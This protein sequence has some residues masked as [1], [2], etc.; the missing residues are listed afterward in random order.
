LIVVRH[1]RLRV[2]AVN[3]LYLESTL[4]QPP[5]S[6]GFG[7]VATPR[8]PLAAWRILEAF[9]EDHAIANEWSATGLSVDASPEF[10]T[11][12]ALEGVLKTLTALIGEPHFV[13]AGTYKGHPN[14]RYSWFTK[15]AER[16]PISPQ[17]LMAVLDI[18]SLLPK[19]KIQWRYPIELHFGFSFF[20]RGRSELQ[21]PP[22]RAVRNPYDEPDWGPGNPYSRLGILVRDHL[23]VQPFFLF[24]H[25]WGSVGLTDLLTEISPKLPFKFRPNYFRR[26]IANKRGDAFKLLRTV[27]KAT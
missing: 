18:A 19:S 27:S 2:K 24:P 20:W 6:Q 21:T 13:P 15:P 1:A 10:W 14:D 5:K 7:H 9:I 12:S 3:T 17:T 25:E 26:A 16:K 4:Y 22:I 23:F 11:P 8:N